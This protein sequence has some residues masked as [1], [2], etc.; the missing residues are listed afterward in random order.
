M[1]PVAQL[2]FAS[3][4]WEATRAQAEAAYTRLMAEMVDYN[5]VRVTHAHDLVRIL[6]PDYP[7]VHERIER[8]NDV[9]Q[10]IFRREH[11]TSL[12]NLENLNKKQARTYLDT[13]PGMTPYVAAQVMLV[14]LGAHAVPVDQ[15]LTDLLKAEDA[16]DEDASLP[17]AVSFVERQFKAGQGLE[18][19]LL[20]RA[21][22]DAGPKRVSTAPK[23]RKRAAAPKK[24]AKK[25]AKKKM[26]ARTNATTRSTSTRSARKTSSKTVSR[27]K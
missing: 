26:T 11:A 16:V 21:W 5:D 27:K 3:L 9:L 24:A 12:D 10:E 14:C 19:H 15:T 25:A 20:L 4:E 6:G 2:I 1:N 13:L 23:T 17:D 8:L 18:A 22:V 7:L